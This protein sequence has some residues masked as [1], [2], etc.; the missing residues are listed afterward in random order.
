[1]RPGGTVELRDATA[2]DLPG[3]VDLYNHY[4]THTAITFDLAP[5]TVASRRP[6]FDAHPTDGPHRLLV[7]VEGGQVLGYA[8]SSRF[9]DKAAYAR[10]VETSVYCAHTARGRGVGSALYRALFD[11]LADQPVHRAYA[12]ITLPNPASVALH[13]RFGFHEVGVYREVGFK[14]DRYHDVVWMERPVPG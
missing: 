5:I 3:L 6:W 10:S 9:R 8:T 11:L 2:K 1:M 7:A 4:I 12:G 14:F 13:R